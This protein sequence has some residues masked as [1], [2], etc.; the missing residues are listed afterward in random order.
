M[1]RRTYTV[2]YCDFDEADGKDVEATGSITVGIDGKLYEILVCDEHGAIRETLDAIKELGKVIE[3]PLAPASRRGRSRTP[4]APAT[5]NGEPS[6]A[7]V[8]AWA[9][10][11]NEAAGEI[12]YPVA[13][14]G[15]RIKKEVMDAYKAAHA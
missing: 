6:V 14:R 7:E 15:P 2:D 11:Q 5:A 4:T 9:K 13:P 12:V 1:G 10:A 3:A 8:R